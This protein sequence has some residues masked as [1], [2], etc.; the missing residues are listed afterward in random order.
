[1]SGPALW[2]YLALINLLAFILCGVDKRAARRSERRI[3]E[4]TL[5]LVAALGGSVGLLVGM[6]SLRHKTRKPRF[7]VGVPAML[8]LQVV[9]LY[10]IIK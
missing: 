9:A 4:R 1:M 3:R 10:W 6:L 5:L 7:A 8:A 2:G